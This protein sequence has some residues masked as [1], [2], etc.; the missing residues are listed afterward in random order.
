VIPNEYYYSAEVFDREMR[1][2]FA[3]RYHFA[4]LTTELENDRDFVCV[5]Y[6]G[7]SIVVQNFK[8]TIRAFQ[9]VCTHRFNRIQLEE[10][11]NGPLT[12]RYHGWSFDKEG[13][14][15][16]LPNKAQFLV[17]GVNIEDLCLT[18]YPVETCGKFVFVKHGGEEET[19]REFLGSFYATLEDISRHMGKE[20]LFTTMHH[21]ANWKLLVENVLDKHHCPVAHRDTFVSQGYCLKGVDDVVQDGLHSSHQ[22]PRSQ[23]Q[24][25]GARNVFLSHLKN[26]SYKHDSYFHIDIFP[27]LFVASSEGLAFYV[28][29]L[30][31]RGPEETD[32]RIRY[33]EANVELSTKH[34][35]RQD[36]LNTDNNANGLAILDED[37]VILENIQKGVRM[38]AKPG[39]IARDEARVRSF[40]GHYQELME[41]S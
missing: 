29:Q 35:A 17:E 6:H 41:L 25:E 37:R 5:D 19:L 11:G 36:Q 13:Y 28:G 26:R 12:C 16:G 7:T 32:L 14:P 9:N 39:I 15:A 1:S 33:F 30:L 38:S 24:R 18:R 21:K 23:T 4:A 2:L 22:V 40:L 20:V 3:S 8:G 34:R 10:R 31:P 27:N